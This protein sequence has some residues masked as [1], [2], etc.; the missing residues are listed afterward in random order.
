MKKF[1]ALLETYLDNE[2]NSE[3]EE[4]KSKINKELKISSAFTAFKRWIIR[5]YGLGNKFEF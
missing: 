3:I 2:N 1:Q 4:L 5:E